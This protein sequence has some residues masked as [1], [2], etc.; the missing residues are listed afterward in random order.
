VFTRAKSLSRY[1]N[2]KAD[3]FSVGMALLKPELPLNIRLIGLRVTKLKDLR[4][5]EGAQSLKRFFEAA[6]SPTE[7]LQEVDHI[8]ADETAAH[9]LEEEKAMAE[10]E[11]EHDEQQL[12][13]ENICEGDDYDEITC[14]D[15]FEAKSSTIGPKSKKAFSSSS[16]ANQA[17]G[18]ELA[19]EST[20]SKVKWKRPKSPDAGLS[21]PMCS[22]V[23]DTDNVG[24]NE[25]IDFCLSRS[26]IFAATTVQ[27][28][29]S[30]KPKRKRVL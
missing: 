13:Q 3:L 30:P 19:T 24:L 2:S 29:D 20:K 25:H 27:G 14:L 17:P 23:L 26:V 21:C 11:D 6:T 18:K 12:T 7:K 1:V 15:L 9:T 28:A 22:K 5:P 16:S 10:C 4:A 8:L